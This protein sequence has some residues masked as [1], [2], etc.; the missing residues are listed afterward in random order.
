MLI[1]TLHRQ[2]AMETVSSYVS[3]IASKFN[4][5]DQF[6]DSEQIRQLGQFSLNHDKH[7]RPR[8]L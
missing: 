2:T 5:K 7:E 1:D 3:R 4:F 6:G 8:A